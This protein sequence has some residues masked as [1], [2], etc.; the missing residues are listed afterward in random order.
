MPNEGNEPVEEQNPQEV[1]TTET[2]PAAT[3]TAEEQLKALQSQLETVKADKQRLEDGY[4]GL[5]RTVNQKDI[6]LKKQTEL[7]SD[8]NAMNERIEL[9]ATA[10]ASGANADEV[11]GV[12][13][14]GKTKIL[15]TLKAMRQADVAKK[16]QQDALAKGEEYRAKVETLGLTT[17]DKV[18][19]QIRNAV[20]SGDFDEAD[21]LI[22]EAEKEKTKVTE[23]VKKTDE[24]APT[25]AAIE[26][27][28]RKK[29]LLKSETVVPSGGGQDQW[30]IRKD[31][32]SGKID[33]VERA[34]RLR[35]IGVN[36]QI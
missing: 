2:T 29:G 16:Q 4:K 21:M 25:D 19:F 13:A 6:E 23:P 5:Q 35:A 32:A 26:A 9:L 22:G 36:P 11:D 7:R 33:S 31:Y 20:R 14:E 34:K 15:D 28:L 12:P 8:I 17:K 30:Q 3:P 1:V 27:Y 10:I 24:V 18:Y